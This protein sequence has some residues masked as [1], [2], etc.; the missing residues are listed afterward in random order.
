M[1]GTR[2]GL[3]IRIS[4]GEQSNFSL[5][6]Q[7]QELKKYCE[8]NELEVYKVYSDKISGLEFEK[9]EG[10]QRALDEAE[11][12]KYNLLLCTETD[13][14]ARDPNVLGYVKLTLQINNI[15]IVAINEPEAKTEYDELIQGVV[16]LFS[17]F[18]AKRRKRRCLRGIKKA[19]E[20]G[21]MINRCPFGYK[22]INIGTPQSK[23]VPDEEKSKIVKEIFGRYARGDTMYKISKDITLPKSTIRYVLL[24]PFYSDGKLHGEHETLIDSETFE[25][26]QKKFI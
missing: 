16:S 5:E 1:S 9:R 15:K 7:E 3:Y 8:E 12:G 2:A 13:R 20:Q 4:T 10:L 25:K 21:K 19:R 26:T 24:N 6:G 18:E 22:F 17:S 11:K 23:V 14:L